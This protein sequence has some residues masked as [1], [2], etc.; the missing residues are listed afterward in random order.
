VCSTPIHVSDA[1]GRRLL[2]ERCARLGNR[3]NATGVSEVMVGKNFLASD[4]WD[5]VAQ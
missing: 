3:V 2:V 5:E 4:D 1:A